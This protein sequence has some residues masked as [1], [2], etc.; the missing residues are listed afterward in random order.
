MLPI[1]KQNSN[2]IKLRSVSPYKIR[3]LNFQFELYFNHTF[4]NYDLQEVDD[5][6]EVNDD[7]SAYQ[8]K[9]VN[10]E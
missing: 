7:E 3:T 2:Q 4:M 5:S 9:K 8:G 10:P 6:I 1:H